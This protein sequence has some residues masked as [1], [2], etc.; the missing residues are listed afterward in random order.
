[1]LQKFITDL[2]IYWR[3]PAIPLITILAFALNG[4]RSSTSVKLKH[5]YMTPSDHSEILA[6]RT[7]VA[8]VIDG[9]LD[10]AIWKKAPSYL[11]A[12]VIRNG[13]REPPELRE[14]G[15][16]HLAWDD[17][18][19]YVAFECD[20]SDV[21]AEAML[22]GQ[23]LYQY[24]DVCELFIKPDSQPWYWE[25]HV[26]PRAQ[27]ATFFWP[28]HGRR[29]PSAM[30]SKSM[31]TVAAQ[32]AGTLNNYHDKDRGWSAEMAV[33]WALIHSPNVSHDRPLSW[34][35]LIGRYNYSAYL[36]DLEYSSL[37]QL[38]KV[39]FHQTECYVK[40]RLVDIRNP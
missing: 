30:S 16:V 36:P 37:P 5:T 40:M 7:P 14:S 3:M 23:H 10:D 18:Y 20:D 19:L 24:G 33:P 21:V 12:P 25:F 13:S 27:Q 31:L 34:R 6:L 2:F 11:L 28:S 39:D 15:R 17:Q 32:V 29:L 9:K 35:I 22:E 4:C 8:V 38:T 1:M 26:S